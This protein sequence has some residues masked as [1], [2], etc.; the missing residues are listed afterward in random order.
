MFRR[1]L[2][3]QV[4]REEIVWCYLNLLG[5]KPESEAVILSHTKSKSFKH[6]VECFVRSSEFR[7][8]ASVT[9]AQSI[10][11]VQL[12]ESIGLIDPKQNEALAKAEFEAGVVEVR[13]SPIM[14]TLETTSRCNLRCV[15]CPHTIDAVDRPKHMEE[16]LVASLDKFIRQSRAIQLHG[17]PS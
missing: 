4:S 6:L 11:D 8:K 16:Y 2:G 9:K 13:S 17:G 10:R 12:F 14:M 5:R 7:A 1:W 3:R 15:M